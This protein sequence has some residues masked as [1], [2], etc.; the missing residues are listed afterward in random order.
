MEPDEKEKIKQSFLKVKEDI[1]ILK[2]QLNE[3]KSLIKTLEK[4]LISEKQLDQKPLTTKEVPQEIS[5]TGNQG[6][7]TNIHSFIHAHMHSFNKHST[8][9]QQ[10]NT[11]IN[12]HLNKNK[13]I[14]WSK[15]N[16][17]D[18]DS[19]FL[20][21]T[22]GEFLCFLTI[23][24][25]EEDLKRGV[26]YLELSRHLS[27]SEGCIRTYVSQMLKKGSPLQKIRLNNKLTL[28]SLDKNFRFLNLK[29]RL[30]NIFSR[31]DPN[32]TTLS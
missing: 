3:V 5:S 13:T 10:T 30:V 29:S 18:I 28:L 19:Y 4:N 27:L 15:S 21:L 31:S 6:V 7:Y 2:T 14:D 23:Y 12:T 11:Q 26:S 24:Q 25:L 16:L 1:E 22:K 32:Q 17:T 20:I 9:I 8:D